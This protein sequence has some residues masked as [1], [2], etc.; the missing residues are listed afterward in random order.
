MKPPINSVKHI[1]QF[2]N[3]DIASA[4]LGVHVMIDA[5]AK[6][7]VRTAT[8]QVDEGS[9]IKAVF[10]EGWL[11]NQSTTNDTQQNYIICKLPNGVSNPTVTNMLNLQSW[12]NKGNVLYTTQG[13]LQPNSTP[14]FP[15]Y[16]G[17]ISVPKGKQRFKLG[18]RFASFMT[19]TGNTTAH[20][21]MAIYK[22]YT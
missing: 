5:V 18:D 9:I 7:T 22:E 4:A 19:P 14:S 8:N 1:V 3:T 11:A 21:G 10:V 13:N 16:K 20:C 15:A 2:S 12:E 17:W 6:S